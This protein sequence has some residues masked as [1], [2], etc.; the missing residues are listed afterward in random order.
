MT[1]QYDSTALNG[2]LFFLPIEIIPDLKQFLLGKRTSGCEQ[3]KNSL[4]LKAT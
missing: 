3:L 4:L 1:F 2:K